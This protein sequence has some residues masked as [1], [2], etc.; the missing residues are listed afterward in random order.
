MLKLLTT[1]AILGALY[2]FVARPIINAGGE[3]AHHQV[4]RAERVV[5]CVDRAGPDVD[6]L[7]ACTRRVD[8]R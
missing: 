5:R 2:L 7:S 4:D 6:R 3:L 8:P 1:L